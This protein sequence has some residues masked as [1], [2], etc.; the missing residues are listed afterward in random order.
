MKKIILFL[1][2]LISILS[3]GCVCASDMDVI[4]SSGIEDGSLTVENSYETLDSHGPFVPIVDGDVNKEVNTDVGESGDEDVNDTP[5]IVGPKIVVNDNNTNGNTSKNPKIGPY[6]DNGDKEI[7]VVVYNTPGSFAD[8]QYLINTAEEGSTLYLYRDYHGFEGAK[9]YLNKN[10]IINGLGH[11]IDCMHAK[12]CIGLVSII[13]DITLK[14][15]NI[16]NGYN[17]ESYCGGAISMAGWARYTL[18]DC[19]FI[20]NWADDRGGAIYNGGTL[21]LTI[22]NCLFKGNTA[23]DYGGGAIYSN[24]SIYLDSCQ[25]FNNSAND[26]GGAIYTKDELNIENS[27]FNSN[28]A[29]I[30]GGAVF[31]EKN[32]SVFNSSFLSNT[33]KGKFFDCFGG[34]VSALEEVYVDNSTFIDNY[35]EDFGGAIHGKNI[36][37][38]SRHSG[39]SSFISNAAGDND[40]GALHTYGNVTMNNTYF[41]DNWAYEDAGA[42]FCDNIWANNSVFEENSAHGAQICDCEG[43]AIFAKRTVSLGKAQFNNNY[44]TDCGGAICA[45]TLNLSNDR[46]LFWDNEVKDKD[47]SNLYNGWS[48]KNAT[49]RNREVHVDTVT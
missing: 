1:I 29:V 9:I 32:I 15:L 4:D 21:P 42:I 16:M 45:E 37:V 41:Y 18:I 33:A 28:F 11:T 46:V 7:P 14:N 24:G 49:W 25:F 8:L 26:C 12:N 48:Y 22:K 19:K 36:Y 3:V 20:N 35:A 43:G 27:L 31:S 10:L 34:A 23:D 13:G 40:G 6:I 5:K 17:D 2:L 38:N 39:L 30:R 44:A 47:D